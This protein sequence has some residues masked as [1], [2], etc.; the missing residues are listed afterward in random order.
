MS[1]VGTY[2][3][4][5]TQDQTGD[6]DVA[7]EQV[8]NAD[9]L[10][11]QAQRDEFAQ[12]W[13]TFTADTNNTVWNYITYAQGEGARYKCDTVIMDHVGTETI[14]GCDLN[15]IFAMH[16]FVN[17]T[18][19]NPIGPQ[20]P[21]LNAILDELITQSGMLQKAA[22][23]NIIELD[24]TFFNTPTKDY[25]KRAEMVG[26][27]REAIG[28]QFVKKIDFE[29]IS[30]YFHDEYPPKNLSIEEA[31]AAAKT[32]ID[33]LYDRINSGEITMKQA[34]DE[35]KADNIKGD[36]TGVSMK[37]LDPLYDL[38]AYL[39][40]EG[41]KFDYQILLDPA[42][43]EELRSLGEGQISTVRLVKDMD[44]TNNKELIDSAF[45]IFKMN[46]IDFGLGGEFT[47]GSSEGIQES[48]KEELKGDAQ[49][50]L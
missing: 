16:D 47:E 35:I 9:M 11:T 27:A 7:S 4:L 23:Q 41:H 46:K 15:V 38:N 8:T 18:T 13:T 6:V 28:D 20:D 26:T 37:D 42:Y 36:T 29:F 30:I 49:I 22:E 48:I 43:D 2:L 31:K 32:K 14:Y 45:L 24:D 10:K 17:Y 19:T 3:F 33:I 50:K 1:A 5:Q 39:K 12:K 21:N 25:P 44:F 40:V 34:G